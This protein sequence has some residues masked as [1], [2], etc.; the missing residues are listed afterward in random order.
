M[1]G[2]YRARISHSMLREHT[3]G[4]AGVGASTGMNDHEMAR[5]LVSPA[6]SRSGPPV[7]GMV[8]AGQLAR[9]TGQAAVSLGI[10]F[11]VLAAAPD[12]SAALVCAGTQIGDHRSLDD[13]T[14]FSA[15]CDIVTFDHEHV[16][17]PYLRA[18]DRAVPAFLSA[19]HPPRFAQDKRPMRRRLA[20]RGGAHP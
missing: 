9:M 16:P 12:E 14:A 15:R 1:I 3:K 7:V 20:G 6:R 17:G 11:R 4:G 2:E 8:G 19:P 18:L 5:E 10:G 13:L